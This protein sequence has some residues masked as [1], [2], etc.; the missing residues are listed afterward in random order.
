MF[1]PNWA[2][3]SVIVQDQDISQICAAVSQGAKVFIGRNL[4]GK[5]KI[6][7]SQ[8]PF[9]LWVQRFEATEQQS[10]ILKTKLGLRQP[11]QFK[12]AQFKPKFNQR[13]KA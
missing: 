5:S 1:N 3:G 11:A 7:L 10:E 6:K 2:S 8:G 4:Y 13:A 12:N 9:G